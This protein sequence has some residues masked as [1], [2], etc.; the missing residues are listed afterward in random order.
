MPRYLVGV[1]IAL[2]L[3][4]A[5]P[6]MAQQTYRVENF[7]PAYFG[8][9]YI[10]D[11]SSVF[12]PGWIAIY[13][14]K[15][16]R[17]VLRVESEELA[18][19]LHNGTALANIQELPYGEQSLIISKDFNFDGRPDLALQDGQ[20][21]CYH[22]PSFQV[23]LATATGFVHS[24]AFTRLAQEY[25]GLFQVDAKARR[26]RTMTKSGCCWHEYAEYTVRNNA[27]FQVHR[28]EEDMMQYP[29][30]TTTEETW[31]GQRTVT[32]RSQ[33]VDLTADNVRVLGTAPLL[34]TQKRAVLLVTD[35]TTLHYVLLRPDNTVEF[36]YPGP[37]T[38]DAPFELVD[39]PAGTTLQFTNRGAVYQFRETAA[40]PLVLEV[41][42]GPVRRVLHTPAATRPLLPPLRAMQLENLRRP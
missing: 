3:G 4:A 40:A 30:G 9:I 15:T 35:S 38:D 36:H 29:F 6:A 22:G 41:Q 24:A 25:C 7:S 14:R 26:L 13:S 27:P 10:A 8:R 23:Y 17:Q 19:N 5:A 37:G 39:T 34:E 31:N 16:H 21:S 33:I 1:W 12:S 42:S 2:W 32:R 20:N 18:L 28:V 11:T